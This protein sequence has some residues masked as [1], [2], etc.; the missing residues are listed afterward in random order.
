VDRH[1]AVTRW[2]AV[3]PLVWTLLATIVV[4]DVL[5]FLHGIDCVQLGLGGWWRGEG[6][7]SGCQFRTGPCEIAAQ[8]CQA[9]DIV[10]SVLRSSSSM[11]LSLHWAWR[12]VQPCRPPSSPPLPEVH[13]RFGWAGSALEACS[14]QLN[15][16]LRQLW[17]WW[18]H[19][20]RLYQTR[21]WRMHGFVGVRCAH[22]V[23]LLALA[24]DRP[25]G[26]PD[27]R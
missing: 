20:T 11:Q 10:F 8:R 9:Q 16:Q 24:H 4:A 15:A 26:W 23:A 12:T 13:H 22:W 27:Q 2:V 19:C 18:H 21:R 14:R 25:R 7:R 3:L 5:H 17:I 6:Q 1:R